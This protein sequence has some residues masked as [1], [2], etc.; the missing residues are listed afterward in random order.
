MQQYIYFPFDVYLFKDLT[1][2]LPLRDLVSAEKEI[3]RI[4]KQIEILNKDILSLTTRLSSKG[5]VE[6]AKSD[7]VETVQASLREKQ[8][9]LETL[10]LSLEKLLSSSK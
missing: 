9:M 3:A 10:Q 8:I 4:R 6:K 1:V 5:F 7:V 2:F